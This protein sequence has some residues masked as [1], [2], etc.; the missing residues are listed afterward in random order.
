MDKAVRPALSVAWIAD[1]GRGAEIREGLLD[2]D[3]AWMRSRVCLGLV[4]T[5]SAGR[6]FDGGQKQGEAAEPV[7][8]GD[9]R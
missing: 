8:V 3:G 6:F 1:L 9:G 2:S 5:I 7:A 4:P